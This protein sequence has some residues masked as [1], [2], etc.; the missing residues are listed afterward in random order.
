MPLCVVLRSLWILVPFALS[1]VPIHTLRS[2]CLLSI[3]PFE[4]RG[5]PYLLTDPTVRSLTLLNQ[6]SLSLPSAAAAFPRSFSQGVLYYSANL[7]YPS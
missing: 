4:K 1:L 3:A 2:R 7:P 5:D 6:C